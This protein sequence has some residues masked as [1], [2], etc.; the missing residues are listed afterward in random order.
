MACSAQLWG[1]ERAARAAGRALS[2][3]VT[4]SSVNRQRAAR[5]RDAALPAAP[6]A[7]HTA[8]RRLPPWAR[9][10]EGPGLQPSLLQTGERRS[11]N[12]L[13]PGAQETFVKTI[14]LRGRHLSICEMQPS[15]PTKAAQVRL[16]RELRFPSSWCQVPG[17]V[18]IHRAAKATENALL[19]AKGAW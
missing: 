6:C 7:H 13:S 8:Q 3:S 16:K 9:C 11:G 14:M 18:Q 10:G 5:L 12:L 19:V 1:R 17:C 4:G 15:S 2:N